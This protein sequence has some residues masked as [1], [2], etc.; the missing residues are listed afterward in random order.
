M[1]PRPPVTGQGRACSGVSLG[2]NSRA[3]NALP[4]QIRARHCGT[5]SNAS[6]NNNPTRDH[7]SLFLSISETLGPAPAS[8]FAAGL[9]G[10][11]LSALA[12]RSLHANTIRLVFTW[13]VALDDVKQRR[14]QQSADGLVIPHRRGTAGRNCHRKNSLCELRF[15]PGLVG[16][17]TLDANLLREDDIRQRPNLL[18]RGC[19]ETPS[20]SNT[21]CGFETGL[22]RPFIR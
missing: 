11:A 8:S 7:L 5:S 17:H 4:I 10:A 2:Q 3:Q 1:A 16:D 12:V 14:R 9:R 21:N 13:T 22:R 15:R 19:R 18:F 6:A 20:H